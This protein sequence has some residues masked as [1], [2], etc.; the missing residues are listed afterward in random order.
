MSRLDS[1]NLEY[2]TEQFVGVAEGVCMIT[3]NKNDLVPCQ[4][5]QSLKN[6]F[7][8]MRKCKCAITRSKTN[9]SLDGTNFAWSPHLHLRL[10]Q[11][12]IE[13]KEFRAMISKKSIIDEGK[14]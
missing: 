12:W 14:N 13:S 3:L 9:V 2:S 4:Q 10:L 8:A 6:P 7:V 11:L 5:S 1:A